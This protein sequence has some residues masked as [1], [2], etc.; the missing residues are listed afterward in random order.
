[1]KGKFTLNQSKLDA[2]M[3]KRPQKGD[4]KVERATANWSPQKTD[5]WDPD[6]PY[7]GKI[8]LARKKKP[9]SW[10]IIIAEITLVIAALGLAYYSY[11]Y[12]DHFHYHVT[13]GYAKLGFPEAQHALGNKYYHG[14]V[15]AL[16]RTNTKQWNI[17]SKRYRTLI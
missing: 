9:D 15:M 17:I 3:R 10:T 1:M 13:K 16:K 5:D 11:Y 14:E 2:G 6:L 12:F 4:D 7:G 8:Y